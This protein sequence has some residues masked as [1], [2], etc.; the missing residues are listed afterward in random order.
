MKPYLLLA[1]LFLLAFPA[2]PQQ[3]LVG[4]IQGI[5]RDQRGAPLPDAILTATNIDAVEPESHRHTSGTDQYG[6][7]EFVDLS[8]GRFSIAVHRKGYRDYMVPV[9]NVRPGEAVKLP[10]IR[11]SP[12]RSG[13]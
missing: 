13:K 2:N 1:V 10:D 9:V 3:P 11:M 6:I 5:I 12:V 4:S 7:F 8:P